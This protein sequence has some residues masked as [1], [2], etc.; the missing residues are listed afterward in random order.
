MVGKEPE[1]AI[2]IIGV[3]DR[4]FDNCRF[5]TDTLQRHCD[6][7]ARHRIAIEK[8]RSMVAAN[9]R[10][11]VLHV[12]GSRT[13]PLG[14]SDAILTE[15]AGNDYRR[16]TRR[17]NWNRVACF[18][19]K[20]IGPR[21]FATFSRATNRVRPE[22]W[23][24]GNGTSDKP[25]LLMAQLDATIKDSVLGVAAIEYVLLSQI[26]TSMSVHE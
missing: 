9:C 17:G 15:L 14:N 6:S 13:D 21:P 10:I 25:R 18:K 12:P 8:C 22:A 1:L 2:G 23:L 7:R 16:P 3:W 24:I 4:L 26:L 5:P 19:C 11:L 20:F